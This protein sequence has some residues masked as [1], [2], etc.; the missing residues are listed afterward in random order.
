MAKDCYFGP[1][2][3][4]H[5]LQ[6]N[7]FKW[8]CTCLGRYLVLCQICFIGWHLCILFIFFSFTFISSSSSLVLCFF[9]YIC[10]YGL[11]MRLFTCTKKKV[12][13]H[14]KGTFTN[15]LWKWIMN[16]YEQSY[17]LGNFWLC[18]SL[19]LLIDDPT[20]WHFQSDDCPPS[21]SLLL[22]VCLQCSGCPILLF[23]MRIN[24]STHYEPQSL[25]D[26][27]VTMSLTQFT[28]KI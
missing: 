4:V 17:M 11:K 8:N 3:S 22:W 24:R 18:D 28:S 25:A 13:L 1:A 6:Y 23:S 26:K 7:R 2:V 15:T 14:I 9:H 16:N 21:D 12:K 19:K 27:Y 5:L 10:V 20:D